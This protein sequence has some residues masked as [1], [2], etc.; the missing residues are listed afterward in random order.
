MRSHRT[1]RPDASDGF[2]RSELRRFADAAAAAALACA[3][4]PAGALAYPGDDFDPARQEESADSVALSL[5][6]LA[7]G[8]A[9]FG[10]A[11]LRERRTGGRLR[12]PARTRGQHVFDIALAYD[13]TRYAYQGVASRHRDLHRLVVPIGWRTRGGPWR[14]EVAPLVATSSNVF[15]D[16]VDRGSRS[17]FDVHGRLVHEMAVDR[18]AGWRIGLQ[19]DAAFGRPK[20][21][22]TAAMTWRAADWHAELGWPSSRINWRPHEGVTLGAAVYPDGGQWH[23]ISDERD[24]AAFGYRARTW[25]AA[26]TAGWTPLQSVRIDLQAGVAFRRHHRFED[27]DGTLVDRRAASGRYWGLSVSKRFGGP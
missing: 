24:G 6:H 3:A 17:D 12:L 7:V 4:A 23:V 22:P 20:V 14:V 26:L 10:D 13:Y 11:R 21:Y 5:D 16:L 25:R 18:G 8:E 2:S 19:R 15:K 9:A 1:H 27:D